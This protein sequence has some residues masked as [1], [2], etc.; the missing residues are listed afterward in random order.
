MQEQTEDEVCV[1]QCWLRRHHW[2]LLFLPTRL[3]HAD[4]SGLTWLACCWPDHVME[5]AW[6]EEEEEVVPQRRVCL[7][8]AV[9]VVTRIRRQKAENEEAVVVV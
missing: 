8:A 4:Q 6:K 5:L 9:N 7:Y 1:K 3:L 2:H